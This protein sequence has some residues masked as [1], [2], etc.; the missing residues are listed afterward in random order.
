MAATTRRPSGVTVR[1]SSVALA[2]ASPAGAT[3][4]RSGTGSCARCTPSRP[5][6]RMDGSVS[7][8]TRKSPFGS[9]ASPSLSAVAPVYGVP[10]GA[11]RTKGSP[12][13]WACSGSCQNQMRDGSVAWLST[14][15]A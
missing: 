14:V 1:P 3:R 4:N 15:E 12:T 5:K 8:L 10:S 11:L 6:T 2:V 9:T 7:E 13:T